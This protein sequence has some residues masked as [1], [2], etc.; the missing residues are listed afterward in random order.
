[1]PNKPLGQI[2]QE[3]TAKYPTN[4]ALSFYGKKLSYQQL[5]SLSLAFASA[6]QHNQVHILLLLLS[7]VDRGIS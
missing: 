2:L 6:L 4:N 1:M 3:T 7:R 5:S